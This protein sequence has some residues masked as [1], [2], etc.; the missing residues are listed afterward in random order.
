MNGASREALASARENL[1][2]LVDSASADAAGLAGDL[3]SVTALFDREVSLRRVLTDPAQPAEAKAELAGR[4]LRGQVGSDAADLVSGLVRSR[5][6]SSRD[7]VDALEELAASADLVAAQRAGQLD[8]VEDELFRFGR[9]VESNPGLR[10]ALT[11]KVADKAAKTE[12]LRT[13]L[14]GRANPV[15]E[16]LVTRLV[17]AP[18]EAVAWKRGSPP[19]P[20]WP[21]TAVAARRRGGH[22]RGAAE[23]PA[24]AAPRRRPR[25]DL[26]EARPPQPGRR[27]GGP[28]RH[29]GAHRR[30]G[31]Q[32][33]HRG[34]AR[35]RGP[36]DGRLTSHQL[37]SMTDGPSWADGVPGGKPPGEEILRAQ[38]G[39]QGTQMAELTI[40]PEEIRDALENFV[41][42]Y[43]P[44]AASREEV[45]T[46][47]LAGDGIAKVEGLPSAMANELL[48]FEDGTL[49]LALNLEEREIGAIV[50]GEFS[51]IEEGQPVQRTG[52]GALRRCGR[53]LPRPRRRPAG[54]PD[55]R[56]RR[57][58]DRGP[59]RPRTAG[60]R[61]HGPQV[62][63]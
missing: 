28:R 23:R 35:R 4:L 36:P 38:Q 34:P 22:L 17:T 5:W 41:Q 7:L 3:A 60:P 39:E 40:R 12:L 24:E 49:G 32:R 1:D 55:R 37:K 18:R 21:R 14:G 56:S 2:A 59:P 29:P 31:H 27:P 11:D 25:P 43:K 33:N 20:S 45:G 10:A 57:D 30:R 6:S 50:L 26:R 8:D 47:S 46:V 42:A 48:K 54:Q 16:R 9:I 13:L 15:T 19:S 62:G 58:Q 53:G 63:P 52:E 51:G 44:D 61:R